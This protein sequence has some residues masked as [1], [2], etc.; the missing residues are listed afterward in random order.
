MVSK[1]SDITISQYIELLD[2]DVNDTISI[3]SIVLDK[4]K[5]DIEDMSIEEFESIDCSF[6]FNPIS[7]NYK[8]KISLNNYDFY[9]IPFEK[10]EFGAFIDLEYFFNQEYKYNIPKILSILYRRQEK[11][12]D[13]ITPVEYERYN[14]WLDIREGIFNQ[15]IIEDVYGAID[16]Y[17]QFR[18]TIFKT[19]EGLFQEKEEEVDEQ[20]ESE[21]LRNMTGKEREAYYKEKSISQYGYEL[22]LMRLAKDEP[23]KMIEAASMPVIQAFNILGMM[24]TLKM[25]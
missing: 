13:D 2:E 16:K 7:K 20:Q 15:S 23:T 19:Y 12:K 11:V 6:I 25:K 1:W 18:S 21:F 22:W 10:L 9:L 4:S 3:Y 14:S 24:Q 8:E 17:I 5:Q